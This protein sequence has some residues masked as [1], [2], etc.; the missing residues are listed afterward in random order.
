MKYTILLAL[1]VFGTVNLNAQIQ[2]G[3]FRNSLTNTDYNFFVRRGGGAAVHINQADS[4]SPIFR[5]GS[6]T[7][8]AGGGV[9]FT[10]ENNGYVGIKTTIPQAPL[11]IG[12]NDAATNAPRAALLLSRYWASATNVRA[13]AIFEY[14][15]G[16][17]DKLIFAV[18]GSGGAL[19]TPVD[20]SQAKMTIQADGNVGIGTT[21]P[22]ER[23]S[24]NGNI[25]SKEIKVETA[26]WPDYVFLPDYQLMPLNKVER[27]I[28]EN[29]HLPEVPSAGEISEK[30]V[31]VG[32]TQAVLLRKIE[33]LT[34]HLIEIEK[35]LKQQKEVAAKQA[36]LIEE[37]RLKP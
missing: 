4:A 16:A 10:V 8:V 1:I 33:E 36:V 6:K 26:N 19:T 9:V 25:R 28:K 23:L 35:E 3:V 2:T 20:I 30:G 21:T 24:V 29:G 32:A 13:G 5:L 37:L 12:E 17:K 22:N 27:F 31:E 15:D 11:H 7:T 34:L 18:S 14:S